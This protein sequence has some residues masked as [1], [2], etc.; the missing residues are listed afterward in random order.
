MNIIG[1]SGS[2]SAPSRTRA[3]VEAVVGEISR[4]T[5]LRGPIIDL[6]EL[7]ADLGRSLGT[8]VLPPAIEEAHARLRAADLIVIGVPVYK[9]SYPGAFKHF[10]DLLDPKALEGKSAILVATGG[11]DQHALIL[12]HQLRALTSYLGMYSAPK[13]LFAR[14]TDFPGFHLTSP[15][16]AERAALVAGQARWLLRAPAAHALAEAA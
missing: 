14:D 6:A 4:Q 16:I 11:S 3:L 2:L 13:T 7:A 8:F 9:A 10:L 5:G 15:A 12:E 1:L